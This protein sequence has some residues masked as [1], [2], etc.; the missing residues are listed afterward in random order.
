MPANAPTTYTARQR[1]ALTMGSTIAPTAAVA[2]DDAAFSHDFLVKS[3]IRASRLV[4]AKITPTQLH[5]HGT[6]TTSQLGD[7]GFGTLHLRDLAWARK[8]TAAYG[9]AAI[10]EQFLKSDVD[11]VLLAGE[12]AASELGATPA[13]L[14]M[15]CA[16]RPEA[17]SSVIS[18]CGTLAGV[19]PETLMLTGLRAPELQ[20]LGISRADVVRQTCANG[21]DLDD[22]GF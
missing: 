14:L 19:P 22:L 18:Q 10:L 4:A 2:M 21:V 8:A 1:L 5:A 17:A 13:L 6:H 16:D 3:G 12:V 7:L 15:L 9:G 11:A 20:A